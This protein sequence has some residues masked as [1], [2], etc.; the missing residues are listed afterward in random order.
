ME[1]VPLRSVGPVGR[2]GV[3]GRVGSMAVTN[4]KT[5]KSKLRRIATV[6]NDDRRFCVSQAGNTTAPAET[7]GLAEAAYIGVRPGEVVVASPPSQIA[8]PFF[9]GLPVD[10]HCDHRWTDLFRA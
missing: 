1:M 8:Q 4:R 2:P 3:V 9:R 5:K 6:Y 10:P 7:F